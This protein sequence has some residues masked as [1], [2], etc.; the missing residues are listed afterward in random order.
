MPL[1]DSGCKIGQDLAALLSRITFC[2]NIMIV[3]RFMSDAEYECLKAG[4]SLTNGIIHG[5]HGQATASVGFCFFTE[6]PDEAIHWLSGC[7]DPEWCVTMEFPD[8]YLKESEATYRDHEKDD[9]F[10]PIG[11]GHHKT[12]K[13]KEYCCTRYDNKVAN[14]MCATQKF[15]KYAEI[16]KALKGM[17]LI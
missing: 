6:N 4:E 2:P 11:P 16:R 14:V 3:H 12:I 8:G 9:L 10:A 5:N 17:G 7:C 1:R 15:C 13:R